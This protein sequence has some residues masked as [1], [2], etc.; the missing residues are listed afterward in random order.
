VRPILPSPKNRNQTTQELSPFQTS[1]STLCCSIYYHIS[2][3][4]MMLENPAAE[5]IFYS[6][7]S[8]V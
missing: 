1:E 2:I 5:N 6:N 8:L 3:W 7:L 4:S